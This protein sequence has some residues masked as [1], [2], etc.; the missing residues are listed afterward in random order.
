MTSTQGHVVRALRRRS[1]IGGENK[2]LDSTSLLLRC[3]NYGGKLAEW[4]FQRPWPCDPSPPL[5]LHHHHSLPWWPPCEIPH[6][7]TQAGWSKSL[8]VHDQWPSHLWL[9]GINSASTVCL[10]TCSPPLW[11]CRWAPRIPKWWPSLWIFIYGCFVLFF[12]FL[13]F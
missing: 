5:P 11:P 1:L 8:D 7:C 6:T 3:F 10:C 13:I 4:E 9:T 12:P 2:A